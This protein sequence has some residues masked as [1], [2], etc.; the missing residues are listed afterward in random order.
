MMIPEAVFSSAAA[1]LTKTLSAKGLMF[2]DIVD[3]WNQN[4]TSA[5]G[6]LNFCARISVQE[7]LSCRMPKRQ[8]FGFLQKRK[9]KI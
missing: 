7:K 9:K 1:G 8:N 2:T 6:K 5:I 4:F 3:I